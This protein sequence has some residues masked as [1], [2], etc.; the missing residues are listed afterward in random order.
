MHF[1][2]EGGNKRIFEAA[3]ILYI[4]FT[5]AEMQSLQQQNASGLNQKEIKRQKQLDK[6]QMMDAQMHS[7]C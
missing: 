1:S 2:Q 6:S 7:F 4:L 5:L 3:F